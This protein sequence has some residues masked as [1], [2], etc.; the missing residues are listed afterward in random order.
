MVL[1]SRQPTPRLFLT[2]LSTFLLVVVLLSSSTVAKLQPAKRTYNTHTYYVLHLDSSSQHLLSGGG[3]TPEEVATALGAEHVERVGELADHYLIR[4]ASDLVERGIARA[5]D[6]WRDT[7]AL[8]KRSGIDSLEKRDSV[9]ET[10][11]LLR[12]GSGHFTGVSRHQSKRGV[13][14]S[15]ARLLGIRSLERQSLRLRVKRDLPVLPP[16]DL[17]V[18]SMQDPLLLSHLDKRTPV[19]SPQIPVVIPVTP[20]PPS[21]VL[22]AMIQFG[23]QDPIFPLQWHLVNKVMGEN[24]VNITGVWADGIHGKGVTVAMVDDGLDMHSDDLAP[25]F[26][27]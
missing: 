27:G 18:P 19:P 24:S 2:L 4:A 13:I 21:A 11:D 25:N 9:M 15:Q 10:Y 3:A 20:E 23:I 26:V 17:T 7:G 1:L 6:T 5:D 22:D 12:R 16:Q 14:G 8:S